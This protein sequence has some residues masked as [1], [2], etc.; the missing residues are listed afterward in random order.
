MAL[1]TIK[2]TKEM[3]FAANLIIGHQEYLSLNDDIGK[4]EKD[5]IERVKFRDFS[6][7]SYCFSDSLLAEINIKDA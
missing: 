5:K 7:I 6:D 4:N 2:I 3:L 1:I